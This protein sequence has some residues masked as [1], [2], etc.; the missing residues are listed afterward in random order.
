MFMLLIVINCCYNASADCPPIALPSFRP[1][2]DLAVF[3]TKSNAAMLWP[4]AVSEEE[5]AEVSHGSFNTLSGESSGSSGKAV[6]ATKEEVRR[7]NPSLGQ[8]N[9]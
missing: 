1:P 5:F 7:S 8:I 2:C 3:V 4:V 9:F 6:L